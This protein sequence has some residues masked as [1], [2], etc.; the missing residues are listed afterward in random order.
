METLLSKRLD[1]PLTAERIERVEAAML[2]LPQP[3]CPLVHRFAPGVCIREV[4]MPAGA[5]VIGHAHRIADFNILLQ[6]RLTLLMEDGS[7]KEVSAPLTFVGTPGRKIAYVHEEVTWQN[8]WAT[9]VQGPKSRVRSP[10][11]GVQNPP[12]TT[13]IELGTDIEAIEAYYLDKSPGWQADRAQRLALARLTRQ[14]DR[15]DFERFLK[16][17]GLT[18]EWVRTVS[19]NEG[20]QVAFPQPSTLN[21]Q[22]D[23]SKVMV[24]PSAIEG[25]GLLATGQFAADEVIAPARVAGRRTPAGRYTNHSAAPN[26]QMVARENG[27]V[28]LVAVR[29]IAGCRGGQP[30]EEI[31]V[32]Y[33]QALA[34]G[35]PRKDAASRSAGR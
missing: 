28:D 9:R 24:G 26:A 10:E 25:K 27:D 1:G 11:S 5:L 33:R 21:P 14:G 13:W 23:V 16:E 8:V 19:E 2:Q 4:R 31:T 34:A 20:D 6:G 3:E 18:A 12:S 30:G 29:A 17:E 35:K 22:L 15:E 32:D 7:L